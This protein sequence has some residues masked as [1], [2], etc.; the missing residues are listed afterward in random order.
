[1]PREFLE[2]EE[3]Q[4]M[5]YSWMFA[6]VVILI[7]LFIATITVVAVSVS[8]YG[9]SL[10]ADVDI[11]LIESANGILLP[12]AVAIDH[13][14]NFRRNIYILT[15]IAGRV[16]GP[17]TLNNIANIFYVV[18]GVLDLNES[19]L[20]QNQIRGIANVPD[21]APH[22]IFLAD[23]TVPFQ[24][25]EKSFLFYG[26]RPRMFN[27]FRDTAE[28]T[29]LASYFTYTVPTLVASIALLDEIGGVTGTVND[30]VLFEISQERVVLRN[31]FNRD[32]FVNASNAAQ[33]TNTTKQYSELDSINPL[34]ATFHVTGT[35]QTTAN[36]SLAA[37][38]TAEFLV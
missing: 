15:N 21:I 30:F 26:N 20:F 22:A 14:M 35:N 10:P 31:D 24:F 33:V 17:A 6:I 13:N 7:I 2:E 29:F 38:L 23:Y 19:F 1:M 32:I 16:N 34:F 18:T 12:Q 4:P 36:E 8:Q 25:I 11:V 5:T 9:A 28:T 27:I 3:E 37:F